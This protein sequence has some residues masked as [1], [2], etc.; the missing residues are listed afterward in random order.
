MA[1]PA[2]HAGEERLYERLRS[3]ASKITPIAVANSGTATRSLRL[4]RFS[5]TPILTPSPN[6][7]SATSEIPG[8]LEV[9]PVKTSP[10]TNEERNA[11]RES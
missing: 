6:V 7:R 5:E 3:I 10:T 8:S 2:N 9:P 4:A 11:T 1:S